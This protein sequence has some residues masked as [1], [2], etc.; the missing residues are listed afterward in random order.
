MW[1]QAFAM[2]HQALGTKK[3]GYY[4]GTVTVCA[5]ETKRTEARRWGG[6]RG[7]HEEKWPSL[8]SIAPS[9]NDNLSA[10]K[11]VSCCQGEERGWNTTAHCIQ[12]PLAELAPL[13]CLPSAT[14]A[15]EGERVR[16]WSFRGKHGVRQRSPSRTRE[17]IPRVGGGVLIRLDCWEAP[18]WH[19]D[20]T[21]TCCLK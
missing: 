3:P 16:S 15:Y 8:I 10:L 20:R 4:Y 17:R 9:L 21:L 7:W 2:T 6:S 12:T 5:R 19:C 14:A 11:V 13:I 1:E 18:P